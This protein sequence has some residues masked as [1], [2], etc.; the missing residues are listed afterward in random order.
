MHLA[1][2]DVSVT[3]FI[4]KVCGVILEG[5]NMLHLTFENDGLLLHSVDTMDVCL[6]MCKC[7]TSKF[8][9]YYYAALGPLR[10]SR[11]RVSIPVNTTE[12]VS[13]LK[14]CNGELSFFFVA[15]NSLVL[16]SEN[17]EQTFECEHAGDNLVYHLPIPDASVTS[18]ELG[19]EDF[20]RIVLDLVIGGSGY[21]T[22]TVDPC[23]SKSTWV[24]DFCTGVITIEN[25]HRGM[26]G[27]S[28]A[29]KNRYLA[30]FF[31][32]AC[33]AAVLFKSLTV[34]VH[35]PGVIVLEFWSGIRR[36]SQR[37]NSMSIVINCI[38]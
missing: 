17:H 11:D 15:P 35:A 22:I 29:K 6:C 3:R 9:Y 13:F 8:S 10:T 37:I 4:S 12:F 24:T 28:G 1:T 25:V 2:C 21:L 30:K 32:L 36:T 18:F 27:S 34:S 16:E 31:K 23:H 33:N 20:V 14:K 7:D 26:H 38:S 5:S 19:P